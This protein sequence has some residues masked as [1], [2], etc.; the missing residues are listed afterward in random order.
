MTITDSISVYSSSQAA[1]AVVAERV[2]LAML[3]VLSQP[4][5]C[6]SFAQKMISIRQ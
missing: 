5:L 1:E 6:P 3:P 2:F 4:V